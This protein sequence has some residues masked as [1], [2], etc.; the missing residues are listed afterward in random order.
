MTPEVV[1][2]IAGLVFLAIAL[3]GGGIELREIRIPTLK[4]P[5]RFMAGLLGGLF[6]ILGLLIT[7]QL[8]GPQQP[9]DQPAAATAEATVTPAAAQAATAPP[10][11]PQTPSAA[12][13]APVGPPIPTPTIDRD[14]PA[15]MGTPIPAAATALTADTARGLAKLARWGKGTPTSIAWAPDSRVFA[16]GSHLGVYL[17]D[18]VTAQELRFFPTNDEVTSL[19]ISPDGVIAAGLEGGSIQQWPIRGG[20]LPILE[21]FSRS[22]V[23]LAFAPD[24]GIVAAAGCEE[25]D[26]ATRT[27]ISGAARVWR[28]ESGELLLTLAGHQKQVDSV[29]FAPD[30]KSLASSSNDKTIRIWDTENGA[31]VRTIETGT[32]QYEIAYATDPQSPLIALTGYGQ[33]K[34]WRADT[35]AELPSLVVAPEAWTR[36]ISLAPDG[37]TLVAA[38]L[39]GTIKL[40]ATDGSDLGV[41]DQYW[42]RSIAFSPDSRRVLALGED[43]SLR[44]WDPATRGI[45]ASSEDFL[46]AIPAF[47]ILPDN[48]TVVIGQNSYGAAQLRQ[49]RDGRLVRT[50]GKSRD[51]RLSWT[52][53][54]AVAPDGGTI[55]TGGWPTVIQLWRTSDGALLHTLEGH[56]A[57]V[58]SLVFSSDGSHL[59]SGAEDGTL[60]LWS[61]ASGQLVQTLEDH[62]E[63]VY[64]LAI[65]PDGGLIA[66]GSAD[67][68]IRLWSFKDGQLALLRTLEGHTDSVRGLAFAPDS[69]TLASASPDQTVRLWS[70]ESGE[71]QKIY[72]HEG[73]WVALAYTTDGSALIVGD[74][75]GQRAEVLRTDDGTLIEELDISGRATFL[76]NL[77]IAGDGRTVVVGLWNGQM[78]IWQVR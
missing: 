19:A 18:G 6:I 59:V 36:S 45:V 78:H 56:E 8:I 31:L 35:G 24:E 29:A 11:A 32:G 63:G 51:S 17:Y 60:R 22:I 3:L 28:I 5:I 48:Q 30:G 21:G 65:S 46:N 43:G 13:G 37:K 75:D 23:D 40:F 72:N 74:N 57:G 27:C 4:P 33:V 49:I 47:A 61:V 16:V 62:A 52:L 55:A 77:V 54:V 44:M 14:A 69:A 58:R 26:T 20:L 12:A 64:R 39:D 50:L 1:L 53:S 9:G 41:L 68:T 15:Q 70:V 42:A 73:S 76:D 7:L 25:Y 10:P 2:I 38:A 71:Q 34:L 67:N 66:S